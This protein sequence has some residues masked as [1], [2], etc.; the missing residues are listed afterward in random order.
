MIFCL[1]YFEATHYLTEI[2]GR[3]VTQSTIGSVAPCGTVTSN[4]FTL[5]SA[6]RRQDRFDVS[7]YSSGPGSW[8]RKKA[9]PAFDAMII[10]F[11]RVSKQLSPPREE[12]KLGVV[13]GADQDQGI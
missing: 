5:P 4:V 3:R 11:D 2:L 7:I 1:T 6:L 8:R 10:Q 9:I 12:V 13:P